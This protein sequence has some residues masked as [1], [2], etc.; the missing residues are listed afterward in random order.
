VTETDLLLTQLDQAYDRR[1]WHGT[2][3]RG[4]IRGLTPEQAAWR[5]GPRRHSIHELIVH[6]A[7][8]KYVVTRRITGEKRGSFALKGSNWFPRDAADAPA[9]PAD[10]RLL[11]DCHRRLRATV[12]ALDTKALHRVAAD[13]RPAHWLVSGIIAHDLYHAGQIQLLKRMMPR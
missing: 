2:N 12:G 4:S 5:P 3:L 1:S 6:C 13:G 8:W 10:L 7:Y 11:E 9:L